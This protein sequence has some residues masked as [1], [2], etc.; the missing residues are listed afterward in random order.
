M[1]VVRDNIYVFAMCYA[2]EFNCGLCE[3]L[4]FFYI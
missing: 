3:V 4:I 1:G 2:V